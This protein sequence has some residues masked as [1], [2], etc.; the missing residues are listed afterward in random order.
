M[1]S[2]FIDQMNKIPITIDIPRLPALIQSTISQ[3][4]IDISNIDFSSL[5]INV[6]AALSRKY[7]PIENLNITTITS[8]SPLDGSINFLA[9]F[10][11]F[12][13]H[14]FSEEELPKANH[15]SK[16]YEAPKIDKVG[17]IIGIKFREHTRGLILSDRV[18]KNSVMVVMNTTYG[19][20]W[21]KLSEGNIHLCGARSLKMLHEGVDLMLKRINEIDTKIKL[22]QS[23][24]QRSVN[25]YNA[26]I[27]SI[28]GNMILKDGAYDYI[29]NQKII[30][31]YEY[32]SDE[33][34]IFD[35]LTNSISEFRY[36]NDFI[37]RL[38]NIYQM[39]GVINSESLSLK[40]ICI[41]MMNYNFDLGYRVNRHQFNRAI[42]G[43]NGFISKY[44]NKMDYA[45][46]V[47]L[48]YYSGERAKYMKKKKKQPCFTFMIFYEGSVTFTGPGQYMKECYNLF[49]ETV[50]Q[51]SK[52]F[53]IPF[54]TKMPLINYS[55]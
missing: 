27:N 44:D 42:G 17:A 16:K 51:N 31:P 20:V 7:I 29:I 26:I 2:V 54:T 19:Y 40:R 49:M 23:D 48:P 41:A 55:K 12:P 34:I 30:N 33:A 15:R 22:L 4:S 46:T 43:K 14:Y 10:N 35:F 32:D 11:L 3:P 21:I 39:T 24:N 6:D 13:I 8:V 25:I 37:Y 52:K 45:V 53:A 9:L 36:L 38:H 18:F 50:Y 47:Q 5:R 1:A 28:K